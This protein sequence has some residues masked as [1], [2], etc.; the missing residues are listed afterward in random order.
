VIA[1]WAWGLLR[2][3]L[4]QVTTVDPFVAVG[5]AGLLLAAT[6][7]A[8]YF[9]ARRAARVNPISALRTE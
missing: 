8:S 2:T 9:P 6:L 4:V 5:S 1:L 3:L 7:L